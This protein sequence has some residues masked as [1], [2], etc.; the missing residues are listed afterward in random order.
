[1]AF[2]SN[3]TSIFYIHFNHYSRKGKGILLQKNGQGNLL[4]D[5]NI[6]HRRLTNKEPT[7]FQA[8]ML[9][10]NIFEMICYNIFEMIC[11][12]LRDNFITNIV[13]GNGSEIR[14]QFWIVFFGN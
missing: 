11:K 10:D 2:Y 8:D 14:D 9:M 3:V 1:M 7:L 13:N 12:N 5:D 6:I 4:N